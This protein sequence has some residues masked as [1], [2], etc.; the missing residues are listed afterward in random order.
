MALKTFLATI[1]TR[2]V[3]E[4]PDN[5]TPDDFANTLDVTNEGKIILAGN[6]VDLQVM[7]VDSDEVECEEEVPA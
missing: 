2:V 4:V 1:Q 3:V 6:L 5:F 7:E